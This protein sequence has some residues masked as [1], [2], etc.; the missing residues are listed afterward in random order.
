M[1]RIPRKV[2]EPRELSEIHMRTIEKRL[3]GIKEAVSRGR[4][5]FIVMIV[6]CSAVLFTIWNANFSR[7]RTL[8]FEQPS[9]TAERTYADNGLNVLV[10]EWYKTR[11]IQVS[12]LGIRVDV[13]DF[14]LIGS[15]AI[16]VITVWY[17]H[18]QRQ[19]NR[20]IIALLKDA[21][22][23]KY[24][25]DVKDYIFHSLV[26]NALFTKFDFDKD[27][28]STSPDLA[29]ASDSNAN[30]NE[31]ESAFLRIC[32]FSLSAIALTAVIFLF[33]LFLENRFRILITKGENLKV[34]TVVF[35]LVILVLIIALWVAMS[36]IKSTTFGVF[37]LSDSDRPRRIK[38]KHPTNQS[39]S[40]SETVVGVMFYLPFFTI[41]A[42]LTRDLINLWM[43]SPA[44]PNEMA[45]GQ[46][47][48]NQFLTGTI[49]CNW[50]GL[51]SFELQKKDFIA[52]IFVLLFDGFAL[53]S[54]IFVKLLCDESLEFT[55]ANIEEIQ[56][57]NKTLKG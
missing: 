47:I 25:K 57:L 30:T 38:D 9:S 31:R 28:S 15:F 46:M 43:R 40:M 12:L 37:W 8:A 55:K 26:M 20:E 19:V 3:D 45:I 21:K 10:E 16:V 24:P 42:I 17:F 7:E 4:S 29:E 35:Q 23:K 39:Y 50:M 48:M 2:K 22:K 49:K 54:A 51:C 44:N 27:D 53:I 13:S 18:C 11:S 56:D 41:L 36:K 32:I 5:V 34:W 52:V 1:V 6:A 14:S 33:P